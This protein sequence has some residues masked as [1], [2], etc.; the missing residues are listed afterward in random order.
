M[1]HVVENDMWWDCFPALC[2][3]ISTR[4]G[5]NVL[6]GVLTIKGIFRTMPD[7]QYPNNARSSRWATLATFITPQHLPFL[8]LCWPTLP[9][10]PSASASHLRT[11]L[12]GVI[13]LACNPLPTRGGEQCFLQLIPLYFPR[14][15]HWVRFSIKE[16]DLV[17]SIKKKMSWAFELCPFILTPP[18]IVSATAQC[19]SGMN[20]EVLLPPYFRKCRPILESYVGV[21]QKEELNRSPVLQ[22][23]FSIKLCFTQWKSLFLRATFSTTFQYKSKSF[24]DVILIETR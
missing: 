8:L 23:G 11:H 21:F 3:N 17:S 1:I 2:E 6:N 20:R 16:K 4:A 14:E 15:R 7:P 9:P 19:W 5:D 12:E 10:S 22:L 24:S 13:P 18:H